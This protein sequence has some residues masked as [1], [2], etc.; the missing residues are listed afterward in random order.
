MHRKSTVSSIAVEAFSLDYRMVLAEMN[1]VNSNTVITPTLENIRRI[2]N[3]CGKPLVNTPVIHV[4]GTNGKGSVSAKI[5]E[6]LKYSGLRTGLFVSPHISSFRE[7]AQV[8]GELISEED[9]CSLMPPIIK[10]CK[11]NNIPATF[12]DLTTIMAFLK[13]E[14]DGC[15]AVVL[16]VGLGGEVDSTNVLNKT[17]LSI[18][19]SVQLDHVRSLGS[20]IEEIAVKKAGIIKPG[21]PVLLG[22]GTPLRL[23]QEEA[24]FRKAPVFEIGD[25]L[26]EVRSHTSNDV[27]M[28]NQDI[29]LAAVRLLAHSLPNKGACPVLADNQRKVA[30]ALDNMRTKDIQRCIEVRPPCRFEEFIIK[31][32]TCPVKVVLDVAHNVDAVDALIAKVRQ[33]Y[34]TLTPSNTRVV[35]AV[36]RDKATRDVAN[37]IL[38][39]V[40]RDASRVVCVDAT[41]VTH[42]ALPAPAL[43]VI[44]EDLAEKGESLCLRKEMSV[45]QGVK[46]ALDSLPSRTKQGVTPVVLVCGSGYIMSDARKSLGVIEPRDDFSR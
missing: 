17:S 28:L 32:P 31:G 21:V 44:L 35:L 11:E 23:L 37:L 24:K 26:A 41:N 29:A 9:V 39:L 6:V 8:N 34:P 33:Q 10:L 46:L 15:D 16:E 4:G 36:C 12:F 13:F 5:A 45:E 14:R 27:D 42:R 43:R 7:R 18:L 25:V 3:L 2:Y 30:L 38:D 22:T 1:R 40:G 20:T 19:T